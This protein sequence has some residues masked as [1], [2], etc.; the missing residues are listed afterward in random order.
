V[1]KAPLDEIVHRSE[2]LPPTFGDMALGG[3]EFTVVSFVPV[4]FTVDVVV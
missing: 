2:L 4:V 1:P 3:G